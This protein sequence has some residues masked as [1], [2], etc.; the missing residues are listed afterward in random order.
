MP[1][2]AAKRVK[3]LLQNFANNYLRSIMENMEKTYLA[4]ISA[5]NSLLFIKFK[6]IRNVDQILSDMT[7]LERLA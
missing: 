5:M 2:S 4:S 3:S 1:N 6:T 7:R